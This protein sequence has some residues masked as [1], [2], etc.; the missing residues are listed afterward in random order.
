[1]IAQ[2]LAVGC[3]RS[4][5]TMDKGKMNEA[6]YKVLKRLS[7]AIETM[8]VCVRWYAAYFV[9][10]A[11]DRIDRWPSAGWSSITPRF[12]GGQSVLATILWRR[13]RP[14]GRSWRMDETN[15]KISG[16]CTYLY[17]AVG[18]AGHTVDFLL[19]AQRQH[20]KVQKRK[21]T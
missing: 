14:V 18:R 1:M 10:P 8:L 3:W 15:I 6:L 13:K 20:W 5:L 21:G 4:K 16:E 11:T 12:I 2:E 7:C 17:R 19:R 9:E